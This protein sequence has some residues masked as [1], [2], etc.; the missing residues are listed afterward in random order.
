MVRSISTPISAHPGMDRRDFMNAAGAAA[1]SAAVVSGGHARAAS[2]KRSGLKKPSFEV[3][4]LPGNP[5]VGEG[6]DG[7]MTEEAK[8]Y[9]YININGPCLIRVPTWVNN[10]LG[11]YYLYFAHHKGRYIRLAFADNLAG[12]WKTYEPGCLDIEDSHFSTEQARAGS[13]LDAL[14]SVWKRNPPEAAWALTRVGL[15]AWLAR[16]E[17]KSRGMETSPETTPHIASPD[18]VV[19]EETREIRMYY[20]GML[21]D[22]NQMSR[23]AVSRD[24]INF[25]ARPGLITGPYLRVFRYRGM[26]YGM[27]MPGLFWRSRDGLSDFEVRPGLVFGVNMRHSALML[28]GSTLYV[29]F[30][31]VGD[32]PERILCSLIDLGPEQWTQWQAGDAVEVLRPELPWEGSEIPVRPSIRGEITEP[33][34]ELRDPAIFEENGKTYLLYSCA[35]EQAIAIAELEL[36]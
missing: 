14:S 10:P 5:I 36:K 34:H 16:A 31:K 20:H 4:R 8:K 29:F 3:T 7:R 32:S 15:A 21:D 27:S 22:T 12:P 17:R 24:G 2:K 28:K 19:V 11:K 23:V 25:K 30:S 35:G 1:L 6:M 9:G 33:V 13:V 26:Y 18:V